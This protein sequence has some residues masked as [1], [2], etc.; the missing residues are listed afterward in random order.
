MAL[1]RVPLNDQVLLATSPVTFD[2]GAPVEIVKRDTTD[3]VDVYSEETGGHVLQQPLVVNTK[4][5]PVEP[6]TELGGWVDPGSYDYLVGP[7]PGRKGAVTRF[8]RDLSSGGADAELAAALQSAKEEIDQKVDLEEKGAPGGIAPL[9]GEGKVPSSHLPPSGGGGAAAPRLKALG[10]VSGAFELDLSEGDV[11]TMTLSADAVLDAPADWPAGFSE[12]FL[13]VVS[14]SHSLTLP[15]GWQEGGAVPLNPEPGKVTTIPLVTADG[16]ATVVVV[17][18]IP[19]ERSTIP[20]PEGKQGKEGP[21]GKEGREGPTGATGKSKALGEVS[22]TVT[23]DLS[24][25][26][27]FTMTAVGDV[28]VKFSNWPEGAAEPELYVTQDAVGGRSVTFQGVVWPEETPPALS[29]APNATNIVPLASPDGGAHVY[30]FKGLPGPQ[31]KEG[32]EGKQG[33]EG[34]EGKQGGGIGVFSGL[35]LPVHSGNSKVAN[36][37]A[38]GVANKAWFVLVLVERTGKLK[39]ISV[40]NGSTVSGTTKVAAFDVGLANGEK[41]TL[42]GEA[43]AAQSGA[44]KFQSIV[45]PAEPAVVQG[46]LLMLAVMN[47]G[48]TGLYGIGTNWKSGGFAELPEMANYPATM[49]L[50]KET[51]V[52]TFAEPKFTTLGKSEIE[53][54]VTA[55]I[56]VGMIG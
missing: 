4:G 43:E 41:F 14:E 17:R 11:F 42:L 31:G 51:G 29:K 26:L 34:K 37:E 21:Q 23:C 52:H 47:T 12:A 15:A 18:G 8:P 19:G 32:A 27:V 35:A 53:S 28:A 40:P 22:G 49:G 25:A 5:I 3:Q 33:P 50:A 10:N 55:P 7:P 48:T 16:G 44:S 46:Q 36:T 38:I 45:F 54:A 9:D 56:L 30:G 13:L 39:K 24:Q 1:N 6:E 2:Q 20:G